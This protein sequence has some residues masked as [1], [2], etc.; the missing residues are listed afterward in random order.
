M[1]LLTCNFRVL[2]ILTGLSHSTVRS[3]RQR[4]CDVYAFGLREPLVENRFLLLDGVAWLLRDQLM[5]YGLLRRQAA[6]VVLQFWPEWMQ[7]VSWTEH[8]NEVTLFTVCEYEGNKCSAGYGSGA[9]LQ[10]VI[11]ELLRRHVPRRM[12]FVDLGSILTTMTRNGQKGGWNL[13]NS[14]SFCLPLDHPQFV[15]LL[16]EAQKRRSS[17][18]GEFDLLKLTTRPFTP[19]PQLRK[20]ILEGS[21]ALE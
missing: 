17:R 12:L 16:R 15:A 13:H 9:N 20:I 19:T 18:Q 21:C 8:R 6:S 2:R 4:Q 11:G 3:D 7:A 1:T 10:Q 5:R 14:G